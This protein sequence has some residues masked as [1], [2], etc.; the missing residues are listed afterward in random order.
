[1]EHIH[2]ICESS[3]TPFIGR[4]LC[5]VMQDGSYYVGR[6]TSVTAAGIYLD[7]GAGPLGT[8]AATNARQAKTQIS[9]SLKTVETKAFFNPFFFPFAALA[10]LFALPFFFI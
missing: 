8:V 5:A 4:H 10:F 3:C 9:K 1:M 2:P 7:G 6:L